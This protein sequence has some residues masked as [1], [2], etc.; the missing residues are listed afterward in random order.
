MADGKAEQAIAI[1]E[2]AV[3]QTP[4]FDAAHYALANAHRRQ[5]DELAVKGASRAS[6]RRRHLELA[7]SEYRWVADRGA[8]YGQ[9]AAGNLMRLY[10]PDELN[11]PAE[12]IKYARLYVALSPSSAIGHAELARLLRSSGDAKGGTV[13]LLAAR[14]A[15]A[16]EGRTLLA[17]TIID[18]L[19]N[20]PDASSADVRALLDYAQPALD[21]AIAREPDSR[22]FILAKAGALKLRADRVEVRPATRKALEAESERMFNRFRALNR[23]EA[24]VPVPAARTPDPPLAIAEP[25]GY[26]AARDAAEVLYGR[27]EY[28]KAAA[29]YETFVKS[30]PAFPP[31]H[32]L[33]L[34]ALLAAGQSDVIDPAL[35]QARSSIPRTPELRYMM[36]T[37][38][39]ELESRTAGLSAADARKLLAET[40]VI[41]DEALALRPGFAGALVY[42]AVARTRQA[43]IETD[44]A[45]VKA[46][47]AEADRLRAQ[48][49]ALRTP[50]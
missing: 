2:R 39:V 45:T 30:N 48:A 26:D 33:R 27:K 3:A 9:L 46:L 19:V 20:T 12:A 18:H 5:A 10:G 38:L 40:V 23:D 22:T 37:S 36:A 35:K 50:Q 14:S 11:Q 6:E 13:A 44:P 24:P 41:L 21:A 7:A 1:F 4:D 42:K 49:R 15:V 25:P 31:P 29:V 47:T 8:E 16:P 17:M 43:R 34:G 28:T 32:Y